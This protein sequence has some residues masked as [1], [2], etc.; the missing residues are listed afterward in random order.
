MQ[1]WSSTLSAIFF[2]FQA[3]SKLSTLRGL[4]R[5]LGP[6]HRVQHHSK[7]CKYLT[8]S[9]NEEIGYYAKPVLSFCCTQ[10][11]NNFHMIWKDTK[12]QFVQKLENND[13]KLIDEW[14][15]PVNRLSA[16]VHEKHLLWS[17][18]PQDVTTGVSWLDRQ[19]ADR[20]GG[21][22]EWREGRKVG[23]GERGGETVEIIWNMKVTNK[24]QICSFHN[25]LIKYEQ[26]SQFR[27]SLVD[28][29]CECTHRHTHTSEYESNGGGTQ[30][31]SLW[32]EY[33]LQQ[34]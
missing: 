23:V 9:G 28:S 11:H 13:A 21:K 2:T 22:K 14:C 33:S 31:R 29:M 16:D 5:Y 25:H 34:N 30:N 17:L 8:A 18:A 4:W 19:A 7:R 24:K 15:F 1:T 12:H 10:I 6:R 20:R 32:N 26:W 27:C 3:P